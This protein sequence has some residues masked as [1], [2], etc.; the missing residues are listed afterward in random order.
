[1]KEFLPLLQ[2]SPLFAGLDEAELHSL[3]SCLGAREESF[4]KETCLLRAGASANTLGLML[5]GSAL[6]VQED[7]WGHRNLMA[8]VEAGQVFAEA[9][10]CAPDAVLNVDVVADATCKVLWLNVGRILTTCPA[11]CAYHSQMIR[12]LLGVLAQKN[13]RLNEKTMHM[14]RRTTRE[15]LLSYLS[16]EARRRGASTFEIPFSRQQLAD[17]LAVE[18]SAMSAEL[19]K[20][21]AAGVLTFEKN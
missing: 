20:L 7:F 17:Y 16:A 2:K 19:S 8:R 5:S 14:A 18:R 3:L 21:R 6:I 15:K 1:M 13:L 9:F 10:A 4:A 11:A 12:N